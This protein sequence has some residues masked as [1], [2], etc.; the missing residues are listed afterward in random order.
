VVLY[1]E[2]LN[3]HAFAPM[4][5]VRDLGFSLVVGAWM[6]AA[7]FSSLWFHGLIFTRRSLRTIH[8][9]ATAIGVGFAVIP[10]T[11][12]VPLVIPGNVGGVI[13]VGLMVLALLC[14]VVFAIKAIRRTQMETKIRQT[15]G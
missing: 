11:M 2:A 4:D 1:P 15:S 14:A 12:L 7:A 5:F 13:E 8:R 9:A 6:Y 3:Q 10:I